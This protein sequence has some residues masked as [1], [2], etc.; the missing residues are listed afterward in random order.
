MAG[1]LMEALTEDERQ[2]LTGRAIRRRVPRGTTLFMEG[3]AV[4]RVG[5]ILHGRVKVCHLTYDGQE[6]MFTLREPGDLLG[7]MEAVT[8]GIAIATVITL[9]P[10]EG[11]FLSAGDF[12][13]FLQE[14]PRVALLLLERM[15]RHLIDSDRRR[16]ELI[17]HDSVGRVARRLVDLADRY[18]EPVEG[19]VRITLPI[20]Q[21]ELASWV[22]ISRKAVNNALQVLRRRGWIQTGRKEIIIKDLDALRARAT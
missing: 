4:D 14:H 13:A 17:A 2:A 10:L 22:G 7:H 19:G 8:A 3:H 20:L 16:L 9:E 1:S 11:L 5:V 21:T 12:R 18:G 15:T 6:V